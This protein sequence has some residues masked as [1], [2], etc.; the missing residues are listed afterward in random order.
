[1]YLKA[2]V[3]S[4]EMTLFIT[5]YLLGTAMVPPPVKILKINR[6]ENFTGEI[7]KIGIS[8][9]MRIVFREPNR[10]FIFGRKNVPADLLAVIKKYFQKKRLREIEASA[11]VEAVPVR[12]E[13]KFMEFALHPDSIHEKSIVSYISTKP[14]VL[15]FQNGKMIVTGI[16]GDDINSAIS[17]TL[18]IIKETFPA[19]LGVSPFSL[20]PPKT[21]NITASASVPIAVDL[22][23]I[24]EK[25]ESR[26]TPE[27]FPGIILCGPHTQ[28]NI[29]IVF[30]NSLKKATRIIIW[31]SSISEIREKAVWLIEEL[32]NRGCVIE[33]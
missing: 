5:N 2:N 3:R 21:I 6:S 18:D 20:E 26:W 9:E 25:F 28:K 10:I 14:T 17:T 29:A 12:A 32:Y 16:T 15:L 23:R 7:I 19:V 1:M 22:L 30:Y 11:Q 8:G 13:R 24:C 33:N 31:G 4:I 27:S